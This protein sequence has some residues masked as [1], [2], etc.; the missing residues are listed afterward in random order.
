[1]TDS[2]TLHK[3]DAIVIGAGLGGLSTA[4]HLAACGLR[5]LVL[6]RYAVLGGSTHVF[7]RKNEWEFDCGVH[8]IGDCG[9][10]GEVPTLLHGLGV[11]D[12]IEWLEMDRDGF[13]RIIGPDLEL[14]VPVGWENYEA[15]LIRTFPGEERA[16]R[17][18]VRIMRRLG[19]NWDRS[20]TPASN[21]GLAK[22]LKNS[23]GAASIAFAPH[24]G[25][26]MS[27]GLSP[28][29]ILAMSVQSGAMA[30]TPQVAPVAL[31]AGY[32]N[33]Y[34]G[35]GGHFPR[36]GG[37][38][39]SAAFAE[40]IQSHGGEIRTHAHVEK[41]L[42]EG[43]RVTGVRLAGG[44][45]IHSDVVVSDADIKRTFSDL[46][47]YEH[48]PRAYALRARQWKMAPPLINAFFGVEIDLSN[49]PN[50]NYFAIP[51]WDGASSLAS[52]ELMT[53]RLLRNPGW[54]DPIKWAKDYAA[55][56]PG[57][58]QCSTRRDPSNTRSA[59]AGSAAIE[60]Q[61]LAPPNP[62]LWGLSAEQVKDGSYRKTAQYKEIKQIIQDGLL[63]RIEQTYPGAR[64][65]V[66]WSELGTP[67][68]QERYTHT[69]LGNSYGLE[70]RI[71]QFGALRPRSRTP[72]A[73]LFVAGT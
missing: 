66:R 3:P 7:R 49:T 56:Q 52:L 16:L 46:V 57:F 73:G 5:P 39:L 69:T 45:V 12:R 10:G 53:R 15:E 59:P 17:R 65:K 29:T 13:D 18:Y 1:M 38:M 30:T 8:Y 70:P 62:R 28:R 43:G 31:H 42:I 21:A 25:L 63:D 68:T 37:Q 64:A 51:N 60:V 14:K 50:S 48:L 33:D 32:L 47:G 2:P 23:G 27:L 58:V 71:S 19:T 6:E 24:A 40:V 72:M 11:D 20:L 36:G 9:P 35:N 34:V 44:E 67:A 55:N 26:M 22:W 4:A 61:T 41:I 54:R